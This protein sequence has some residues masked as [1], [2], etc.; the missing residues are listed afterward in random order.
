MLSMLLSA[1]YAAEQPAKIYLCIGQS[2]MVGRSELTKDDKEPLP[3]ISWEWLVGRGNP[4]PQS[5][6]KD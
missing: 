4:S 3:Q 5:I 6:F 2:N 1:V